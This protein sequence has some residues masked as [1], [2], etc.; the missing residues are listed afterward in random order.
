MLEAKLNRVTI[1]INQND[2][3]LYN[4]EPFNREV[5][6]LVVAGLDELISSTKKKKIKTLKEEVQI[7]EENDDPI[8][9]QSSDT[10]DEEILERLEAIL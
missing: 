10:E 8:S 5:N 2:I 9:E 3:Q 6:Q 4:N 1:P 7:P